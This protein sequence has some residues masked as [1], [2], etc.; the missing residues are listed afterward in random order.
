MLNKINSISKFKKIVNSISETAEKFLGVKTNILGMIEIGEIESDVF[1]SNL[2][3]MEK[4][5]LHE[6][7][8][9][10]VQGY[11]E[12]FG[13]ARSGAILNLATN[14]SQK[15]HEGALNVYNY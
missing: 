1:D 4:N 10:L 7:F 12:K 13:D 11:A 14:N 8:I 15:L 9:N 5:S 3:K 6:Q 2:L